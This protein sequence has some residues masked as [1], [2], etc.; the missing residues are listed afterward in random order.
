[1]NIEVGKTWTGIWEHG[2]VR[3]VSENEAVATVAAEGRVLVVHGISVGE[4]IIRLSSVPNT[5]A[6]ASS[7]PVIPASEHAAAAG[8]LNVKVAIDG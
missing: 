4:T 8:V 1:M 7:D 2:D 3:A 5:P 6:V